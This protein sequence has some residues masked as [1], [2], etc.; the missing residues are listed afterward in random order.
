MSDE[1]KEQFWRRHLSGVDNPLV[2]F[3]PCPCLDVQVL[4]R[5]C[6]ELEFAFF[7]IDVHQVPS[8]T[9]LIELFANAMEFPG[10]SGRNW[11]VLL[12]L[13][14]DLSWTKAKG[15]VLALSNADSLLSLANHGFSVLVGVLEATV[16]GWRDES[17]E[18]GERRTPTSFHVILSGSARLRAALLRE[19]REPLCEHEVDK[20][21]H[22]IRTP[23]TI[24]NTEVFGDAQRL[25]R[26]GA[27]LEL[28]LM[29]LRDRGY[30][31]VDSIYTIAALMN[32]TIPQANALVDQSESWSSQT[33]EDDL[34]RRE[35]ARRALRDLGFS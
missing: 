7:L 32:K 30:G 22:V 35:A 5:A 27:D 14:R 2:H 34:K 10:S 20:L 9:E 33:R 19:L 25:L 31:K 16:R 6:N 26:S 15:Y 11:D 13:T 21:V 4:D 1:T 24:A 17:D 28:I 18:F 29:F 23:D 8:A 3:L 12:D